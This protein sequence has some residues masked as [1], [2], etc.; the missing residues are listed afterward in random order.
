ML[1]NTPWLWN[2]R[3]TAANMTARTSNGIRILQGKRAKG[4]SNPSQEY[5]DN[6]LAAALIWPLFRK[7]PGIIR[8]MFTTIPEGE[9]AANDFFKYAY[10]NAIN[11][12]G[13]GNV[14]ITEG[15]IL[16]SKGLMTPTPITSV[17]ADD[18]DNTIDINYNATPV[19]ASQQDDDFVS[20]IAHNVT[21]NKWTQLYQYNQRSSIQDP[22]PVDAGFM[23]TGDTINVWLQFDAY[24]G[25][26]NEGTSSNSAFATTVV[27]A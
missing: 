8:S 26:I 19:D 1:N 3:Q 2:A 10:N 6:Q 15:D 27:V 22:I 17:I 20:F 4:Q 16:F 18:S 13:P 14:T 25:G 5:L 21:Q 23:T 24:P 7:A 12:V 11:F 9:Y